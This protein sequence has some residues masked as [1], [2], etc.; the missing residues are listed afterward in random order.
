[1][2]DMEI[3]QAAIQ[4]PAQ[5]RWI[6]AQAL[7]AGDTLARAAAE[8]GTRKAVLEWLLDNDEEFSE[9]LE[10]EQA[11]GELDEEAWN[12][13]AERKMRQT[14]DRLL[15]LN[16]VAAVSLAARLC[17]VLD[18]LRQ[19][20]KASADDPDEEPGSVEDF[21]RSLGD[22]K[23]TSHGLRWQVFGGKS[24]QRWT[25]DF[26]KKRIQENIVVP[27]LEVLKNYMERTFKEWSCT[28]RA[29]SADVPSSI[30]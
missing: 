14:I 19:R 7:A 11:L 25:I 28:S 30:F 9:L 5:Q 2:M 26:I 29:R 23:L 3:E 18:A 22:D 17:G 6:A 10:S 16:R 15:A 24:S 20:G 1:M 27:S 13:H 12:R 21:L 4:L 8:A